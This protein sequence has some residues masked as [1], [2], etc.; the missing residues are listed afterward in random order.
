M[1]IPERCWK[2]DR[3]DL[4]HHRCSEVPEPDVDESQSIIA[5]F[6]WGTPAHPNP[7]LI[8][9]FHKEIH[10]D[11]VAEIASKMAHVAANQMDIMNLCDFAEGGDYAAPGNA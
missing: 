9:D 8:F 4:Q 6:S 11:N 5:T 1:S 7:H 3:F 10:P 2:C